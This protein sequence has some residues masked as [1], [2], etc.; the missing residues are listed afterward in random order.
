[1][2]NGMKFFPNAAIGD[3]TLSIRFSDGSPSQSFEVGFSTIDLTAFGEVI[4][5]EVLDW[6][7]QLSGGVLYGPAACGQVRWSYDEEVDA[8][9]IHLREGRGQ[10]QMSVVCRVGLDPDRRVV[11]LEVPIPCLNPSEHGIR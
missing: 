5:V 3:G 8:F 7:R 4:G 10:I 9:Y 11:L 6:R 1:M 2:K